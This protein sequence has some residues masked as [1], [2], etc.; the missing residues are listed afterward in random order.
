[1]FKEISSLSKNVLHYIDRALRAAT[2]CDELFGGIIV[3]LGG[4]F[5]QTPPVVQGGCRIAQVNESIKMD[6][7]FKQFKRLRYF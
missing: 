1:M 7:I 4:D 6:P 2:G 3:V 5:K